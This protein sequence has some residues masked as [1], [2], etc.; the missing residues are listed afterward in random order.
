MEICK[1][2]CLAG[3]E[4]W[5]ILSPKKRTFRNGWDR[6]LPNSLSYKQT[7]KI[8]TESDFQDAV[9]VASQEEKQFQSFWSTW[10]T[11]QPRQGVSMQNPTPS[12]LVS[13]SF[14]RISAQ[15]EGPSCITPGPCCKYHSIPWRACLDDGKQ[16]VSSPCCFPET[17]SPLF[18]LS[19]ASTETKGT[20]SATCTR[21]SVWCR[22]WTMPWFSSP[23]PCSFASSSR[24]RWG[25]GW[26]WWGGIVEGRFLLS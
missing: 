3:D 25:E 20:K 2:H 26:W 8:T 6:H 22:G 24:I 18:L 14:F 11:G 19:A 4:G 13:S 12:K 23:S 15:L 21:W 7:R 10:P 16:N 1:I 5:N 9:R 17:R